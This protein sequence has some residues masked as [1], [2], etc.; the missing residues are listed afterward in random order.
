MPPLEALK[1]MCSLLVTSHAS[2]NGSA[3]TLK[4]IQTSRMRISNLG[5][6]VCSY[7]EMTFLSYIADEEGHEF[8]DQVLKVK[9]R[10]QVR[11]TH[12]TG[13]EE[14]NHVCSESFVGLSSR[15]GNDQL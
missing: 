11:W 3:M 7:T 10:V 4:L 2:R 8:V 9:I 6:F 13:T 12:W 14:A 5:S 1:L 15:N